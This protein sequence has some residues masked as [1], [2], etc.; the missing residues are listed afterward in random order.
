MA[1]RLTMD[2]AYGNYSRKRL[3]ITNVGIDP[4]D[5]AGAAGII[6]TLIGEHTA[7]ISQNAND[8]NSAYGAAGSSEISA[9]RA[10]AYVCTPNAEFMMDAQ[11]DENFRQ[12]LNEADL[13]LADGAGIVLAARMLGFGKI[14]RAPG[15]DLAK[16]LLYNPVKYP[17]TFYFLGGRPGVAEKAAEN[18]VKISP[19]TRIAGCRNGYFNEDRENEIIREI[20]AS[21]ADILF[22]ALG[23]PKAEKWIYKNRDKLNVAVCMGVGGTLDIFAETVKPAPPFF[24]SH[25]LE[26]LY[27]LYR[28]PWRAK[29]MMKL[30]RY[31]LFTLWWRMSGRQEPRGNARKRG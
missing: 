26:W 31:V 15:F 16:T 1:K 25:G 13:V 28:E 20:N 19:D 18:I 6:T 22:V 21:G 4:V 17:Y 29:R 8:T 27:R 23:A 11:E 30:P 5:V 9:G 2:N 24:R 14:E 10:A 7:I 3:N 12:I